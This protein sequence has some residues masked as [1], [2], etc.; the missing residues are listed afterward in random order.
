MKRALSIAAISILVCWRLSATPARNAAYIP[1]EL[2]SATDTQYPIQSIA[3]GIV[4]LDLRVDSTG[5]VTGIEVLRDIPSLTSVAELSA[6]SWEFRPATYSG[7]PVASNI[8]AAFAFRPPTILWIPPPFAP[9]TPRPSSVD[10]AYRPPGILSVGYADYPVDSVA[11]GSVVV[12]VTVS[13]NGK[14]WRVAVIRDLAGFT[15]RAVKA[16]KQWR[17]QPAESDRKLTQAQVAISFVFSRPQLNP[18]AARESWKERSAAI[19]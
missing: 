16:G 2:V 5:K 17:F 13:E 8:V 12:Q 19:R 10:L 7:T 15:E 9:V 1:A 11:A 4:V 3:H 18:R 14:P 6:R